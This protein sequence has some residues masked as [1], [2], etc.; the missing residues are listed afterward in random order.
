MKPDLSSIL[1][2]A[3]HKNLHFIYFSCL[4]LVIAVNIFV[5]FHAS[6]ENWI[7]IFGTIFQIAVPAYALVPILEKKDTQGAWQMIF[8]LVSV[9]AVT[10][11]LK[12]TVPAKRPYGGSMSFPSGHT[13]AVFTGVIF[14]TLRY[15]FV[16]FLATLPIGLFVAYSRIYSRNHWPI[17]VIASVVLC[18]VLG[19][20]MVKSYK[21]KK[22]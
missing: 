16:Y 17:D 13:A 22:L 2:K 15:G 4:L 7:E 5:N 12:F 11:L 10:Y 19:F 6:F 3:T 21:K 1:N 18:I 14:L 9:L 8:L 20:F